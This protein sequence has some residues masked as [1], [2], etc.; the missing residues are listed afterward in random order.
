MLAEA[1]GHVEVL[2]QTKLAVRAPEQLSGQTKR[3]LSFEVQF[4]NQGNQDDVLS[5]RVVNVDKKPQLSTETLT[6]RPGQSA[7]VTVALT[8]E[9]ASPGYEYLVAVEARS[10]ND[11]ELT[12]RSRTNVTFN[13]VSDKQA[14]RSDQHQ[15]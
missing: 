15:H 4:T 1:S 13:P 9:D 6:L 12:V 10:R 3:R 7:P 8:V 2:A 5:L 14:A 11:P